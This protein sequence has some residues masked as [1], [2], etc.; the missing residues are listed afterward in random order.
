LANGPKGIPVLRTDTASD[1]EV[2]GVTDDRLG[3]ERPSLF[4]IL[5]DPRRPVVTAQ[6]GI[7]SSMDD[8]GPEPAGSTTVDPPME[9]QRDLIRAAHVQMIS[10]DSFKPHP[11]RLRPVENAGVG[12]FELAKRQVI[13]VAS[14]DVGLAKR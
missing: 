6:G 10:D 12:N 9:N 3:P 5:L 7:Y 8:S 2:T 4:E 14:P 13:S 1:S 11:T